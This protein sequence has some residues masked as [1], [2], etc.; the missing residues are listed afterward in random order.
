[1]TA[2]KPRTKASHVCLAFTPTGDEVEVERGTRDECDLA[3][4]RVTGW[5]SYIRVEVRE[6]PAKRIP[7]KSI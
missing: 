1:M 3:A 7:A 5:P 2:T 6:V 4:S